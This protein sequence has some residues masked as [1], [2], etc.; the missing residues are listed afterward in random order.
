M[1]A[2]ARCYSPIDTASLYAI[3]ALPTHLWLLTWRHETRA[4]ARRIL[5]PHARQHI[6]ARRQRDEQRE[7][8]EP[9]LQA[10]EGGDF[11]EGGDGL[12]GRG[13][14]VAVGGPGWGRGEVSQPEPVVQ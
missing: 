10:E 14:V 2:S 6:L 4:R 8:D 3:P 1:P 13:R 11:C 5:A 12:G 9:D 7:R